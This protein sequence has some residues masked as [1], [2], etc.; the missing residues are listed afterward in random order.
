[1]LKIKNKGFTLIELLVVV[2]IIGILASVVLASLNSARTKG[3]D[4]S[5]KASIS[6]L[7]AQAE[8]YYNGST[9]S[10]LNSY[11]PVGN[12]TVTG[13]SLVGTTAGVCNDAQSVNLLKA[14]SAQVSATTA[15]YCSVGLNG[16]TYEADVTLNDSTIFC[17]DGSGFA[18]KPS[19]TPTRLTTGD[20]KCQ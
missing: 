9:A 13:G 8:I 4:A 11:G 15:V 6:S 18:G 2:A 10:P 1:M 3:K 19:G 12:T 17:V 16:A 20:V 7:R 5:A 14:V